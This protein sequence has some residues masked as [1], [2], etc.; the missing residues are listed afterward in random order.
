[1]ADFINKDDCSDP[2]E[3]RRKYHSDPNELKKVR[4]WR[5]Q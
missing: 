2:E 3:F 1:M 4:F 5:K